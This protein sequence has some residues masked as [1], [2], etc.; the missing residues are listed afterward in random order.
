MT[1]SINVTKRDVQRKLK[2][3]SSKT[4]TRY[5]VNFKDPE[6]KKRSQK[7][8]AKRRD[9]EEFKQQLIIDIKN[10]DYFAKRDE[11]TVSDVVDLWFEIRQ[12]KI[13]PNSMSNHLRVKN[14][15]VGPLLSGAT[16]KQR[17]DFTATGIVPEGGRVLRLLRD[18]KIQDLSPRDIRTWFHTVEREVGSY[19]A[20]RARHILKSALELGAED[21][22]YRPP[23]VPKLMKNRSKPK[24]EILTPDDI[25]RLLDHAEADIFRGIYYAFPFLAGTRPSEQLAILWEDVDFDAGVIRIHR[26]QDPHGRVYETTKTDAG[27]RDIPMSPRLKSMLLQHRLTCSRLDGQLYRVFPGLGHKRAWPQIRI[28]GG[29]LLYQNWRK[30]FWVPGLE[31]ADVPYV[32]PHSARHAFISNLQAQGIEVGL[33]AKIAGHANPMVTLGHYTQAVRGGHEA[34]QKIDEAYAGTRSVGI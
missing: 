17:A 20:K 32:T 26:S 13:K 2:D 29:Q 25:A 12:G 30:R 18:V 6:T 34:I 7:F 8:F 11:V 16:Q 10:G 23:V 22:G 15:I 19:S 33:V 28:G 4:L 3:G 27:Q 9:A 14:L 31:A 5:V 1:S 21:Y 24:K